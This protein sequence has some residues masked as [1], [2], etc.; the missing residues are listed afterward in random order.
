MALFIAA[1]LSILLFL[2]QLAVSAQEGVEPSLE[3]LEALDRS[4]GP[5]DYAAMR[6]RYSDEI[7]ITGAGVTPADLAADA[8]LVVEGTVQDI[9]Y[10]YEGDNKQPHT[11]VVFGITK[12]LKGEYA[13]PT[14]TISQ[15]GGPSQDGTLVNIVSHTE[16]F[17]LD[18]DELLFLDSDRNRLRITK[19]FRV[20]EGALYDTDGHGL[21]MSPEGR[22]DLSKSRHPA[23][24]FSNIY[25]GSETLVKNF[26]Q[27]DALDADDAGVS[28]G[29]VDQPEAAPKPSE[30]ILTLDEFAK[31]LERL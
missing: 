18:E 20:Y 21:L 17:A 15:M 4:F 22:L 28:D 29:V 12:V 3:E 24:R 7:P 1:A 5:D 16:F 13:E 30:P 26:S 2:P 19:R 9:F 14:L 10:T 23:E 8:D 25:I 31:A 6:A 27:P 11:Q